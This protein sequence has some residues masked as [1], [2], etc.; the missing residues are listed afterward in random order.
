MW[1][2]VA[3]KSPRVRR[4]PPTESWNGS[5]RHSTSRSSHP[6]AAAALRKVLIRGQ[7]ES[8][9]RWRDAITFRRDA[10]TVTTPQTNVGAVVAPS[11]SWTATA[12]SCCGGS[13]G[14]E[15]PPTTPQKGEAL[16][17]LMETLLTSQHLLRAD[18]V[19]AAD[20]S[21]PF[22]S[23]EEAAH[24]ENCEQTV[25]ESPMLLLPASFRTPAVDNTEKAALPKTV[26][27]IS[28]VRRLVKEF[29][30]AVYKRK[31]NF[32]VKTF[33]SAL[34]EGLAEEL[35]EVQVKKLFFLCATRRR[36][37]DAYEILHAY[38]YRQWT[39]QGKD[40]GFAMQP[41]FPMY[42]RMCDSLR[43]MDPTTSLPWEMEHLARA[44]LREVKEFSAEGRQHCLPVI[45]SALVQQRLVSLG[46]LGRTVFNNMQR[47]ED[48]EL[49][50]S[51]LEHLLSHSKYYRQEDLPYPEVLLHVV[52][53]GRRPDPY[54][55][56][57]VI[58]N[59][60]PFTNLQNVHMV[61]QALVELESQDSD[62]DKS[63]RMDMA[64]LEAITAAAS[65][66][67][68]VDIIRLIWE[69]MDES[70]IEPTVSIY[71]STAVTFVH[72]PETYAN[73][74]AVLEEMQS[75]NWTPSRSLIRSMSSIV[76]ESTDNLGIAFETVMNNVDEYVGL[77][78]SIEERQSGSPFPLAAFNVVLSTLAERGDFDRSMQ[79]MRTVEEEGLPVD[80]NTFSFAFEALGKHIS[81]NL[82]HRRSGMDEG[83]RYVVSRAMQYL[84][85]MESR[86]IAPTLHVIREY[87]ELLCWADDIETAT[88]VVMDALSNDGAVSVSN[89]TL[90][91]VAM[92][93]AHHN[94]FD[95][96]RELA[97]MGTEDMSF[98]LD[99]INTAEQ[100]SLEEVPRP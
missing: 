5:Y 34:K 100:E 23:V 42:E 62:D 1:Q 64:T 47:D 31:L 81:F 12:A 89:K 6:V 14:L 46:K 53:E 43:F 92:G 3:R 19:A 13:L 99:R 41:Y 75:R 29:N 90:Y 77:S 45:T 59:L 67:G 85:M 7:A 52:F 57:N 80:A 61:M 15:P 36:P 56:I 49:K 83:R 28:R 54:T 72:Q 88:Q 26:K 40:G 63:Y 22:S 68:T 2:S 25:D 16:Q 91:R 58:E 79:M 32:A 93:N 82:R 94:K 78:R 87:V 24:K 98:L 33:Y 50:A 4:L 44:V 9:E 35:D 17:E 18:P 65:R 8:L 97:T 51:Y 95:R 86:K 73:S 55:V 20:A 96:A 37:F 48:L 69:Y 84:V 10:S 27:K 76:R 66:H 70:G 71:E 21:V 38:L 74:F 30:Q 60:F 39:A 11:L